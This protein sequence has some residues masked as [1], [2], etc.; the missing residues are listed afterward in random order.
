MTQAGIKKAV[1][2]GLYARGDNTQNSDVDILAELPDD[3]TLFELGGLK[4]N[5][6][7]PLKMNVVVL[8]YKSISPR[9][10]DSIRSN[11]YPLL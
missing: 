4:I 5:L 9:I 2:F 3:A 10:K 8:T 6:E 1:L 7:E 11:Q